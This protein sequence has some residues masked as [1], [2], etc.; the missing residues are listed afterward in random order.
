MRFFIIK[1]SSLLFLVFLDIFM[2]YLNSWVG[3][4]KS[5]DE[6]IL[7]F[8]VINFVEEVVCLKMFV[9]FIKMGV[10]F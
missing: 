3:V 2:V 9:V 4:C 8:V 10:V 6:G 1:E 7:Y 5:L